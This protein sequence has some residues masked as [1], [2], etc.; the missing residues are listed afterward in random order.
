MSR[1]ELVTTYKT[2]ENWHRVLALALAMIWIAL[3]FQAALH[4]HETSDAAASCQLC[5][6]SHSA[7]VPLPIPVLASAPL[8]SLAPVVALVSDTPQKPFS[9]DPPSRAPPSSPKPGRES[10]AI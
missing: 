5:Q 4:S 9:Q 3:P 6:V 8:V 10:A 1:F 7:G 2:K